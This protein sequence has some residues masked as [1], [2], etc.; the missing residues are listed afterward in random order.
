MLS[1]ET[2]ASEPQQDPR[3]NRSCIYDSVS[4]GNGGHMYDAGCGLEGNMLAFQDAMGLDDQYMP[5]IL[6]QAEP[7]PFDPNTMPGLPKPPASSGREE[8]MAAYANALEALKTRIRN[9]LLFYGLSGALLGGVATTLLSAWAFHARDRSKPVWK[10]AS[11]LG[12]GSFGL[13]A[14]G[15]GVAAVT[16]DARATLFTHGMAMGH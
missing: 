9:Q 15:I 12:V 6:G 8:S 5:Q 13:A 1:A 16:L 10:P 14:A 4:A 11:I 7:A 2:V 3:Y